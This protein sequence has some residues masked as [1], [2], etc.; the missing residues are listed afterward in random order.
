[1]GSERAKT[2]KSIVGFVFFMGVV[3]ERLTVVRFVPD[4]DAQVY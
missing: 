3:T 4:G 1:M 2:M